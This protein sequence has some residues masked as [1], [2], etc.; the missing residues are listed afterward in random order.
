MEPLHP[1]MEPEPVSMVVEE[2][3]PQVV[4]DGPSKIDFQ[5]ENDTEMSTDESETELPHEI[6]ESGSEMT[7]ETV[8]NEA[9]TENQ[10]YESALVTIA[11]LKEKLMQE[12]AKT[13]HF[14]RLFRDEQGKFA[15][16][17]SEFDQ[18]LDM[19]HEIEEKN[20]ALHTTLEEKASNLVQKEEELEKVKNLYEQE[21]ETSRKLRSE[22][23]TKVVFINTQK[24]Q[25]ERLVSLKDKAA[26]LQ[27]HFTKVNAAKNE[28][29]KEIQMLK[30]SATENAIIL[31]NTGKQLEELQD[32]Y[33]KEQ[34]TSNQLRVQL[35]NDY[36]KMEIDNSLL[37]E[38]QRQIQCLQ[39]T[40]QQQ[41]QTISKNNVQM[42]TLQKSYQEEQEL[43]NMLKV[44]VD[45][46]AEL[47]RINDLFLEFIANE[48]EKALKLEEEVSNSSA[49]I[50]KQKA[51]IR[52]LTRKIGSQDSVI[53]NQKKETEVMK[54][55][56]L[57]ERERVATIH[58]RLPKLLE[59][60][61]N[62]EEKNLSLQEQLKTMEIHHDAYRAKY[63]RLE[64]EVARLESCLQE[65][66]E[67]ELQLKT[68]LIATGRKRKFWFSKKNR[69]QFDGVTR[70]ESQVGEAEFV[71][72]MATY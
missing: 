23:D 65:R 66:M 31:A 58:K 69:S 19:F 7:D 39:D 30:S 53:A 70:S 14:E 43:T 61:K 51:S 46:Q 55:Q 64:N 67:R 72:A 17:K 71:P 8:E 26:I 27:G 37:Q 35:E 22:I 28:K 2:E 62:E 1:T 15:G 42:E 63:R 56:M 25:L 52:T 21:Q 4:L 18:D 9:N 60:L 13:L 44:E 11:S 50:Q 12:E 40:V 34:E 41:A 36:S 47:M 45:D 10:T 38:K 33:K 6:V 5:A 20:Q 68:M 29:E 32:L 16:F 3:E 24:Q 54:K 48:K 49:T 57:R 59:L